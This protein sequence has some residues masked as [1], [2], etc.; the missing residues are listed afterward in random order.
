[1]IRV[2]ERGCVLKRVERG[3]IL[4]R[5]ERIERI[6]LS[7]GVSEV[8]PHRLARGWGHTFRVRGPADVKYRCL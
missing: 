5:V 8:K 2:V 1:M 4:K 7:D 6:H 3:R